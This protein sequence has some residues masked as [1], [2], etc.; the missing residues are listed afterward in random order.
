MGIFYQRRKHLEF[1]CK[2]FHFGN[3]FKLISNQDLQG[4]SQRRYLYQLFQYWSSE[5]Y[6]TIASYQRH[7]YA[8]ANL[9]R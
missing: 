8:A 5:C 3:I 4:S 7:C 6:S 2:Y 9:L 1:Y